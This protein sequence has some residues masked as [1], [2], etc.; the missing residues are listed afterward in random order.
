MTNVNPVDG[1]EYGLRL[2][3][4]LM[5]V[6]V[7]GGI[8][9][10]LGVSAGDEI[11][12]LLALVGFLIVFGGILGIQFKIIA[13]AVERGIKAANGDE[14][15]GIGGTLREMMG[16]D[17]ADGQRGTP[18][19]QPNQQPQQQGQQGQQQLQQGQQSQQGQQPQ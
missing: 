1:V 18:A 17:G 3:G 16:S 13:D 19:G 14:L 10:G 4:H 7:V 12:A 11:G 5:A 2:I 8:V 9:A 15:P 6:F